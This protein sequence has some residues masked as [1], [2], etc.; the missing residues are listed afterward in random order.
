VAAGSVYSPKFLD[1]AGAA[2]DGVYTNTNFFPGEPG[3]H[4]ARDYDTMILLAIV[5]RQFGIGRTEI[6][7]GL[8]QV[9]HARSVLFGRVQFDPDTQRVRQPASTDLV[10]R[11]G[12]FALGTASV[13][14]RDSRAP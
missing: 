12:A 2:A 7:N 14:S 10:V 9:K 5:M 3:F 4:V 13:P 6:R 11:D 1:L 8:V